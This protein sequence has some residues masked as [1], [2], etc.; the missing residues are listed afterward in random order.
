MKQSQTCLPSSVHLVAAMWPHVFIILSVY[1]AGS[2]LTIHV[3]RLEQ[4]T[5][6]I[7]YAKIVSRMQRVC[8]ERIFLLLI[9]Y[10]HHEM[11]RLNR[12]AL[13]FGR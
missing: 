8:A 3:F 11:P 9:Q 10:R 4:G 5:T 12:L 7:L 1:G 6:C 2:R 13:A